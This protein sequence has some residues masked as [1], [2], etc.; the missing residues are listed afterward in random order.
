[1]HQQTVYKGYPV[2]GNGLP[3]SD[4]LAGEV[5]ALP[6]HPY[7]DEATQDRVVAAVKAALA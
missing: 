3:V 5:I 6:M 2:A 7:L 4:R 1:V